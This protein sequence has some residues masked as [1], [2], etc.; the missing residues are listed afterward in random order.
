MFRSCTDCTLYSP[1]LLLLCIK[2]RAEQ[3]HQRQGGDE[4]QQCCKVLYTFACV[5]RTVSSR[6]YHECKLIGCK[7]ETGWAS[8]SCTHIP[9][10]YLCA[11]TLACKPHTSQPENFGLSRLPLALLYI[12]FQHPSTLKS[13]FTCK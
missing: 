8:L 6:V 12:L 1:R 2:I 13:H 10:D 3:T 9:V 4:Y 7:V 11:A 5:R